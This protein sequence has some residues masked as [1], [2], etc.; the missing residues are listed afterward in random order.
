MGKHEIALQILLTALEKD[1]IDF[2]ME[3]RK[4]ENAGKVLADLYNDIY[5]NLVD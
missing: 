2:G 5:K 4:I 3:D 1:R